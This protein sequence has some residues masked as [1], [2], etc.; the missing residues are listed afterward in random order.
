MQKQL[1]YQVCITLTTLTLVTKA[2]HMNLKSTTKKMIRVNKVQ[3]Y[4]LA[5]LYTMT[6][7]LIG[8][9]HCSTFASKRKC[10]RRTFFPLLQ[11]Y[12]CK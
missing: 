5:L 10:L 6:D 4:R 12:M 3:F 1:E 2:P 8:D 9:K 7:K 11:P